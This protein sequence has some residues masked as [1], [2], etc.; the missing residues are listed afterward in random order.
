M[1]L[2]TIMPLEL[3]LEGIHQE[4]PATLEINYEG[5]MLQVEPHAA[6]M[7]KIVRI[8]QAPL[9]SYLESRYAPGAW[10]DYGKR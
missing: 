2:H 1:T 4:P 5:V 6:G 7:G 10:I 8:I 3:V 9:S